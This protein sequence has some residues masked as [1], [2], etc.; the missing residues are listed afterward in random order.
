MYRRIPLSSTLLL[1]EQSQIKEKTGRQVFHF[2]FGQSPFPIH[3]SIV[4]ELKKYATNN[5]YL[6]VKGLLA[7]TEQVSEFLLSLDTGRLSSKFICI[8]NKNDFIMVH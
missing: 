8:L 2:G 3:N 7:L 1:N 6:P 5:H 4:E